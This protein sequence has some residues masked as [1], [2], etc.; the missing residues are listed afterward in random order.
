MKTAK[1]KTLSLKINLTQNTLNLRKDIHFRLRKG[2]HFRAC[3]IFMYVYNFDFAYVCLDDSQPS[4]EE[5]YFVAEQGEEEQGKPPP[6]FITLN[7]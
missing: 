1:M 4:H 7:L 5:T 2:I 3:W 6:L